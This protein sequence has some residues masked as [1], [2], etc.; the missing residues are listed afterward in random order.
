MKNC[1]LVTSMFSGQPCTV[2]AQLREWLEAER[3][4]EASKGKMGNRT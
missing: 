2:R 4:C 1:C 3:Q